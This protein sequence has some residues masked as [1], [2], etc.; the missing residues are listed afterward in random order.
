MPVDLL[1]RVRAE[2]ER[3][4]RELRPLVAEYEDL[5]DA[6]A[7]LEERGGAGRG[8]TSRDGAGEA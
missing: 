3:R 7:A 4:L 2:I 1:D 5:L 6:A 8:R